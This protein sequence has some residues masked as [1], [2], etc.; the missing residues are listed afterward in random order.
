ML[1]ACCCC[2]DT[3][4]RIFN[5]FTVL[6]I[7]YTHTHTHIPFLNC[8]VLCLPIDLVVVCLRLIFFY[9]K[10]KRVSQAL[11]MIIIYIWKCA[12]RKRTLD[13]VRTPIIIVFKMTYH[14]EIISLH[15]IVATT[16]T[17]KKKYVVFAWSSSFC[18]Q[19][20]FFSCSSFR[21]RQQDYFLHFYRYYYLMPWPVCIYLLFFNSSLPYE[22]RAKIN[23]PF[24]FLFRMLLH[25]RILIKNKNI[26]YSCNFVTSI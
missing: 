20:F 14:F 19:L 11:E 1:L 16:T 9:W 18:A 6:S 21:R 22:P 15:R 3:K 25:F 5:I 23:T 13:S 2:C 7:F 17:N 26:I 12:Y 24:F 4:R 10:K 8:I